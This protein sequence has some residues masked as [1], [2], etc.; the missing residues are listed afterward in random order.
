MISAIIQASP[1]KLCR[2]MILIKAYQNTKEIFRSLAFDITT[3]SLLKQW[4]NLD[5]REIRQIIYHLKGN[6]E[7]FPR[8]YF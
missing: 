2:V 1:M 7:S 8:T 3:A 5:L 6:D 4:E